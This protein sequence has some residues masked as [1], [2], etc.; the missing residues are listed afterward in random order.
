VKKLSIIA[1]LTLLSACDTAGAPHLG[2]AGGTI[3]PPEAVERAA[4]AAPSGVGGVFQMKV[5][6]AG[7]QENRLYLNSEQDYRDQRNL[8]IAIEPTAERVLAQRLGGNVDTALMGKTIQV[9]GKAYRVK[10]WFFADGRQ[11]DKYYYQTLVV[12]F[13]SDQLK[14]VG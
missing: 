12:L 7:R 9:R 3:L 1:A 8:T 13:D 6:A 4:A 2:A 14:I 11:T 10:V 5:R